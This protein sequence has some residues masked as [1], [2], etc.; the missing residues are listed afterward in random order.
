[1]STFLK[2]ALTSAVAALAIGATVAAVSTPASALDCPGHYP[3]CLHH[4][5]HR[6]AAVANLGPYGLPYVYAYGDAPRYISGYYFTSSNFCIPSRNNGYNGGFSALAYD[7]N[8]RFLGY[9]CE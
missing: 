7:A 9:V 1:M 4:N 3:G 6:G 2:N 8:G 5:W